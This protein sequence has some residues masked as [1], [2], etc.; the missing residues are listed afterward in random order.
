MVLNVALPLITTL[1]SAFKEKRDDLAKDIGVKPEIVERIGHAFE[2][3]LSKDERIL[4]MAQEQ[5]D[6]ARAH[7]IQTQTKDIWII[8][9]VR[10]L[11]RPLTTFAAFAWYIYARTEGVALTSEDYAIIGGIIAFWFGFRPFEKKFK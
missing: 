5:I 9:F 3:Y 6:K 4:K 7:D 2:A 1:L 10:G 8:N 11:V